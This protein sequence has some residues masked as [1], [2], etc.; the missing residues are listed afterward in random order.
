[1]IRPSARK[2]RPVRAKTRP[3]RAVTRSGTTTTWR[4]VR[5]DT[6]LCAPRHGALHT[7]WAQCARSLGSLGVHSVHPT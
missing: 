4:S 2:T 6:A 5:H 7:I 3:V 1:M